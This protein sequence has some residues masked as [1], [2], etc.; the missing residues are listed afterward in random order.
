MPV[1]EVVCFPSW[2]AILVLELQCAFVIEQIRVFSNEDRP[3]S[4]RW[5]DDPRG[6]DWAKDQ[7]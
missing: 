5:F 3:V 1:V 7:L 2:F 4:H 6:R